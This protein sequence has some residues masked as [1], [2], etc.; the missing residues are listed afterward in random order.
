MKF[1]KLAWA[2]YMY[3]VITDDEPYNELFCQG[4]LL[5]RLREH[6]EKVTDEEKAL[7]DKKEKDKVLT[8]KA[9]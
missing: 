4:D 9:P 2:A 8:Q 3:N 5:M 7:A 1:P 6:P